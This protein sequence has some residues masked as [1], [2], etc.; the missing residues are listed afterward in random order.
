MPFRQPIAKHETDQS[1]PKD[2]AESNQSDASEH[3][4]VKSDEQMTAS[5]LRSSHDFVQA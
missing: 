1:R 5:R 3:D 2:A 4:P